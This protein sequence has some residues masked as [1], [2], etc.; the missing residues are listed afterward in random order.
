MKEDDDGVEIKCGCRRLVGAS[1]CDVPARIQRAEPM[2]NRMRITVAVAPLNA[3]RTAQRTVPA[4]GFGAFS[5]SRQFLKPFIACTGI[6]SRRDKMF[7]KR[8]E[9]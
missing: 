8:N 4:G 2:L 5:S 3:A 6:E 9:L 1:R 7:L